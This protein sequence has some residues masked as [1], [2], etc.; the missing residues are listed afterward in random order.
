[1]GKTKLVFCTCT[2]QYLACMIHGIKYI[3]R[4]AG[5]LVLVWRTIFCR[6]DGFI[7]CQYLQRKT[8]LQAV[9]YL[10]VDA[11]CLLE[12]IWSEMAKLFKGG[13]VM[14]E[15][16]G[17]IMWEIY[18]LSINIHCQQRSNPMCPSLPLICLSPVVWQPSLSKFI[19]P[20]I[21]CN[22]GTFLK[23]F[24]YILQQTHFRTLLQ[25]LCQHAH[26]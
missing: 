20:G 12:P 10:T 24:P 25:L 23:Q 7:A 16:M 8:Y 17:E 6:I 5:P 22:L 3:I 15:W 14:D 21:T 26:Q 1:M 19:Q 4:R 13:W 11:L 9:W 18:S 2:R